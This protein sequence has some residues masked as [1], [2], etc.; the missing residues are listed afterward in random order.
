MPV[1]Q[2][3]LDVERPKNS[4]V[5]VYGKNKNLYAVRQRVGCKNVNG[6][7]V[8]INGP[9]IGHIVDGKYIPLDE[10]R[11]SKKNCTKSPSVKN[12]S[13][14]T[15]SNN[16]IG[17]D[18][19]DWANIHFCKTVSES[20]LEELRQVYPW[21]D[22]LK[23]FCIAILRVCYPG[24]KDYQLK[25]YYDNSFLSEI[26]PAVGLSKNTVSKFIKDRGRNCSRIF[27]FMQNRAKS[28]KMNHHILIDGTLKT[29]DSKINSL[30]NFSRKAKLKGRKDISVIYAFDLEAMEPIC[31]KCYPG[32]MLD[33][34]AYEDFI[35]TN[36]IT[37]GVIVA[38]KGFP[39]S[40]AEQYYS[41]NPDLHYLNP[42]K[43]NSKFIATHDLYNYTDVHSV[44]STVTYCKAKCSG[45]NKWLYSFRDAKQA[46]IEEQEWIARAKEKG[47]FSASA[48]RENQ[49]KFGTI[50][51]ECNLDLDPEQVYRIYS[52]RWEIE[53][54]MRYYKTAC[55]FDDTRV[56][57]DYS[58]IGSEFIDFLA[59]LCTWKM[60]KKFDS[61]KLL[62]EMNYKN[63]MSILQRAKKIKLP[64]IDSWNLIKI[65]PS[66]LK[67]LE[68][69]GLLI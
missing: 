45:L 61:C 36:N 16:G 10:F 44:Y 4:V 64:M 6:R 22:A 20:V 18:L 23:L 67:I 3:I 40:M 52:E 50:I 59:T 46:A 42:I 7:H 65:N 13:N 51:L 1:P 17:V 32:N 69:L 25:E 47:E 12:D 24:I 21:D 39:S 38:D 41:K 26:Y 19:K 68:R 35:S 2:H 33:V 28:I 62:E 8:P 49:L 27:T 57:D 31:S 66:Q 14:I 54:V 48:L 34:T 55:E 43:R 56:H 29:N 63:I 5:I 60:I 37:R 53:I 58:V 9:T 15:A 30:S 11:K